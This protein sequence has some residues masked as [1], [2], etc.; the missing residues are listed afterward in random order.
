MDHSS[1]YDLMMKHHLQ[2]GRGGKEK[3]CQFWP[4]KIN[5]A[6]LFEPGGLRD[7]APVWLRE[8]AL[9]WRNDFGDRLK[10]FLEM[11]SAGKNKKFKTYPV[12]DWNGLRKVLLDIA[13]RLNQKNPSHV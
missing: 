6:V 2:G 13:E 12:K 7:K 5:C 8:D 11:K 3:Y 1:L 9:S 4:Q 10:P